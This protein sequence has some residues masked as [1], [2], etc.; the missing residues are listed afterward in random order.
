M[1]TKINSFVR[2]CLSLLVLMFI[3]ESASAQDAT[4]VDPKHY[5][6]EFENDL[7]RVLRI[8]YAPGEKSIMH[9]HPDGVVVFLT[10]SKSKFTFTDGKIEES[11]TKAGQVGWS[12]AIVHL[13]ENTGDKPMEVILIEMKVKPLETLLNVKVKPIEASL[14][15]E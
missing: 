9:E 1:K 8:T 14:K 3:F 15:T 4:K 12:S 6:V 13:P 11:T 5:K 10:D 2:I 7:V